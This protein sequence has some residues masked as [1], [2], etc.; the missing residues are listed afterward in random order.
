MLLYFTSCDIAPN[1]DPAIAVT[2]FLTLLQDI[3]DPSHLSRATTG[4]K[5]LGKPRLSLCSPST[6]KNISV[7]ETMPPFQNPRQQPMSA[8]TGA[9]R[10][11]QISPNQSQSG[12]RSDLNVSNP[13]APSVPQRVPV[14][15][16]RMTATL[17]SSV[18]HRNSFPHQVTPQQQG[19]FTT[20]ERSPG[21]HQNN[22]HNPIYHA[23]QLPGHPQQQ[24]TQGFPLATGYPSQGRQHAPLFN[25][26]QYQ[27]VHQGYTNGRP[28]SLTPLSQ[29]APLLPSYELEMRP[30]AR[31]VPDSVA[32]HQAHVRSP[33]A[34]IVD[35]KGEASPGLR[36]YQSVTKFVMGPISLGQ[37]TRFASLT[38]E[39]SPDEGDRKLVTTPPPHAS[40]TMASNLFKQG[41]L[42]WRLKCIHLGPQ[43][44]PPTDAEIC[45][46]RSS[47]PDHLFVTFNQ[48]VDVTMRRKEHYGRDLP[49]DLTSAVIPGTN[50]LTISFDEI[51]RENQRLRK[52][53]LVVEQIEVFSF[54]QCKEIIKTISHKE[55]LG[56]IVASMSG[57]S[58]DTGDDDD[59]IVIA[60]SSLSIDVTDPFTAQMWTTPVRGASCKHRECFDFEQFL[61]SRPKSQLAGPVGADDWQ[62]PLCKRDAR[63]Q[64]LVTDGFLLDVSEKLRAHRHSEVKAILVKQDGSWEIKPE[65]PGQGR[66]RQRKSSGTPASSDAAD[67]KHGEG[68]RGH[69]RRTASVDVTTMLEDEDSDQ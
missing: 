32:L 25:V 34:R 54:A 22:A 65:G 60:T 59:E 56:Q 14:P 4:V 48:L 18:L 21:Q 46:S 51:L 33:V 64:H 38:F 29:P 27:F 13:S 44:P 28:L 15:H 63:P 20:A 61:S 31:P 62:C 40:L 47:W 57:T 41:S 68:Q 6:Q 43:D 1:S 2:A 53:F 9:T 50:T 30:A 58:G 52:Y 11:A 16:P 24:Y 67:G 26:Q 42:R 8:G 55:S 12:T 36:L 49:A 35:L 66:T 17:S 39:I 69:E 5:Y 45:A 10:L 19:R 37:D 23:V 3:L 7:P